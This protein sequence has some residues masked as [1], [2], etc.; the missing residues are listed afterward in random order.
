MKPCVRLFFALSFFVMIGL[1]LLQCNRIEDGID[2]NGSISD[3]F[4]VVAVGGTGRDYAPS[5][6][7][8]GDEIVVVGMTSSHGLGD[9]GGRTVPMICLP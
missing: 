6:H 3:D 7:L 5:F 4:W 1:F 9:G 8:S 2:G